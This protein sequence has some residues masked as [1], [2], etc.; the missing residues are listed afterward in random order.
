MKEYE[1]LLQ[2]EENR[3]N[4][5]KAMVLVK[6][7]LFTQEE[8]TEVNFDN[9]EV[10]TFGKKYK[11][12]YNLYEDQTNG[13]L[14]YINPLVENNKDDD[15]FEQDLKPYGYDV[16][17]LE[18]MSKDE[19]NNV[20]EA[21]RHEHTGYIKVLYV[22]QIVVFFVSV[23]STILTIA[24]SIYTSITGGSE[25]L[26]SIYSAV[27]SLPYMVYCFIGMELGLLVLT[28]IKYRSFKTE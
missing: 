13:D 11:G 24:E 15:E 23:L 18:S 28:S 10:I 17:S 1:K 2:Q 19:Y 9:L 22:A 4:N 7:G 8:K 16:V 21:S 14:F 27:L 25:V 3:K 6:L 20:L 5:E 26:Y 12:V